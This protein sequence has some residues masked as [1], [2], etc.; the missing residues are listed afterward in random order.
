MFVVVAVAA[1]LSVT[2]A[3]GVDAGKR[4]MRGGAWAAGV[5]LFWIVFLPLYLIV[6]KPLS[7]APAGAPPLDRLEQLRVLGELR[8][9]GTLTE[10]EFETE[11]AALLGGRP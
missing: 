11:K 5:F 6:R 1:L 2:I 7:P 10:A 8:S 4:G 3:V 9:S